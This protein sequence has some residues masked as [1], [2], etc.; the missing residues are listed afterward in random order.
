MKQRSKC[1]RRASAASGEQIRNEPNPLAGAEERGDWSELGART[2]SGLA[3]ALIG[4][5][6]AWFG[7][8]ALAAACGAAVVAMSYEWARMSEPAALMP[9]F[10]FTLAGALGAVLFSSWDNLGYGVAWLAVCAAASGVRRG[11]ARDAFE[12]VAGALYIGLP[13]AVFLWLRDRGPEGL[14]TILALFA[15]IWAADIFA[16]FGGK[17]VGGARISRQLSPNK[18]WSGIVSGTLAGALAGGVCG[19]LIDPAGDLAMAWFGVGAV[20]G[21]T[22]LMGDLFESLLKRRFGVKD[23]S[24]L[25]PGHGGV[26]DRIDSLMAATLLAG[27]AFAFAPAATAWLFRSGL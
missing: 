6:A 11:N 14:G 3:L 4:V 23:A 16:Y 22:G 18:T 8:P 1:T 9:A 19:T 10:G 15:I 17:L 21:F 12:T 27:A 7:G 5:T 26:L 25:I 20:V 2:A 24:R 13:A